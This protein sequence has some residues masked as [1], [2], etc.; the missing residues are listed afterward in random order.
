MQLY[1]LGPLGTFSYL[2]AQQYVNDNQHQSVTLSPQDSLYEVIAS[3]NQQEDALAIV[4][5]ENAIEG[6][7]NVVADTIIHQNVSVISEVTLKVALALYGQ[8]NQSFN[9]MTHVAS[10]DP[11]ISQAQQLIRHHQFDIINTTSTIAA[12][13]YINHHTGA[14][15]P[16]GSGELYGYTPLKTHIEDSPHNMTRF[17]VLRNNMNATVQTGRECLLVITPTY[18]K[19]GLLASILNTFYLFNINLKWIASRPLKTKLGMYRF[20]VQAEDIDDDV[21]EKIFTI[22]ETLDFEILL[23]GRFDSH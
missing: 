1:Y 5:I 21:L 17:L 22:L 10:I 15:A 16:L 2:A 4:P 23:L 7:I 20:F 11:A 3:L 9:D 18:D 8:P 12:L 19:P 14:I 6:T 13:S